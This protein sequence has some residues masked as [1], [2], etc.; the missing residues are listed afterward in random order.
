MG[1]VARLA[2]VACLR[3]CGG[4]DSG[5]TEL[6]A[7][8][9]LVFPGRWASPRE[10]RPQRLLQ[11]GRSPAGVQ[12][13]SRLG[14]V[15]RLAGVACLRRS[16][17]AR[18]RAPLQAF[19]STVVL[20]AVRW[21]RR[22]ILVLVLL[23]PSCG[24]GCPG[25]VSS[26]GNCRVGDASEGRGAGPRGWS[27]GARLAAVWS[28]PGSF[29]LPLTA[30]SRAPI[31]DGC[32]T[33]VARAQK[34]CVLGIEPGSS[35]AKSE[36]LLT[37]LQPMFILA[38]PLCAARV[39]DHGAR[40]R[41]H[42]VPAAGAP[43]SVV[44]GGSMGVS[45]LVPAP[46]TRGRDCALKGSSRGAGFECC[47]RYVPLRT[48]CGAWAEGSR[49]GMASLCTLRRGS[50][51]GRSAAL[52]GGMEPAQRPSRGL[53]GPECTQRWSWRR[54]PPRWSALPGLGGRPPVCSSLL[55]RLDEVGGR[56]GVGW[57]VPSDP[58]P[59]LWTAAGRVVGASLECHVTAVG[60]A[61]PANYSKRS[62]RL[63][64][65]AC[66]GIFANRVCCSFFGVQNPR[67]RNL[68]PD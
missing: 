7:E 61:P 59:S 67:F 44:D 62:S 29:D 30:A 12:P 54:Q 45:G 48:E 22:S 4:A 23:G 27:T 52:F 33:R 18:R 1:M 53:G 14:V 34:G 56:G 20:A 36:M 40:A 65:M 16:G 63:V 68:S 5:C 57:K 2:G 46:A 58:S 6:G 10:E 31:V 43:P 41:R 11:L 21:T 50:W 32:W 24:R 28:T 25:V 42:L 19:S 37:A 35:A 66:T 26:L 64:C 17:V 8:T 13:G 49:Y 9:A 39:A 51:E 38:G 55:A 47:P 3:R 60:P 15:A